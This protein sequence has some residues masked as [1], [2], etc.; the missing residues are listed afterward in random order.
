MSGVP[1][2][3]RILFATGNRHKAEEMAGMLA[4]VA[5]VVGA[6]SLNA[7]VA[8]EETGATFAENAAIKALAWVPSALAAGMDFV[9]ADDSG[10]EVDALGGAPGVYSARFAAMDDGRAGNSPDAENNAKLLRLLGDLPAA[11]RTGRFRCALA[12][13][14]VGGGAV[15]SFSGACEGVIAAAPS[16]GGG[17]GYDPLFIPNG[18]DSSFA[19][20]GAAVKDRISHRARAVAALV[21]WLR[22]GTS[23][24][25]CTAED[26]PQNGR[27]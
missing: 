18:F 24:R 26:R 10:L 2:A 8:V 19:E 9:L 20:L 22:S 13:A 1:C 15:H 12:L 25:A 3:P 5:E 4:G 17:F 23:A 11:K 7:K 21:A 6:S 27:R 16:G 14:P